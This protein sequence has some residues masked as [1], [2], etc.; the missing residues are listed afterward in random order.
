MVGKIHWSITCF[1]SEM[2]SCLSWSISL[3]FSKTAPCCSD[4]GIYFFLSGVI[5]SIK[6]KS[7]KSVGG[8]P[9]QTR[10]V[11]GWQIGERP[12]GMEASREISQ[13]C[14]VE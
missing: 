9:T 8:R 5:V 4:S 13:A 6:I 2:G 11:T 12:S 14:L 7:I 1:L 3:F 10:L